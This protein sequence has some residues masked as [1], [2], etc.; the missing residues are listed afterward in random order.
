MG[1]SLA[2]FCEGEA[3]S[4]D[5]KILLHLKSALSQNSLTIIP[6]G[7]KRGMS[8]F[9]N[10]Y[11]KNGSSLFKK[12]NSYAFRDRDFDFQMPESEGLVPTDHQ[13]VVAGFRTTIENYLLDPQKFF[14]YLQSNHPACRVQTAEDA[15]NL[16]YQ[17][18]RKLK[19]YTAARHALGASRSRIEFDTTWTGGSGILPERFDDDFCL[20]QSLDLI[21]PERER[22][23]NEL[24]EIRFK[25]EYEQ[26]AQS[27]NDNFIEQGKYLKWFNGK[28][29]AEAIRQDLDVPNFSF[30]RYYNFALSTF[31]FR[32]FPDLI[33]LFNILNAV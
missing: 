10:G 17:A 14:Q 12:E 28:D 30:R 25:T 7:G 27:F 23:N 21:I 11:L 1:K 15:K 26:F 22:L 29:L 8:S 32:D 2:V 5:Y 3:Q 20:Q 9:M 16:F 18:A 31:N 6:C 19:F 4:L 33:E 24:S 13:R